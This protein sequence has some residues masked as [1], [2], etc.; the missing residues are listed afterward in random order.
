MSNLATI[1]AKKTAVAKQE[2]L[3][4]GYTMNEMDMVFGEENFY[5]P[6][7]QEKANQTKGILSNLV[8]NN[9]IKESDKKRLGEMIED[10]YE[11]FVKAG[12]SKKP[13]PISNDLEPKPVVAKTPEKNEEWWDKNKLWVYVGGG[14]LLLGTIITIVVVSKKRS[15]KN[16]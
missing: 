11:Y 2:L 9:Q 12:K 5:F 14:A 6:T 1:Y 16:K 7:T 4:D 10:A 15:K 13:K 3:N 8:S